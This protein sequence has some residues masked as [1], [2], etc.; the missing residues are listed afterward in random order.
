M[1]SQAGKDEGLFHGLFVGC[2]LSQ[3]KMLQM[4][5]DHE[6]MYLEMILISFSALIAVRVML[7]Q[8]RQRQGH[9]YNRNTLGPSARLSSGCHIPPLWPLWTR[10]VLA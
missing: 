4:H 10:A 6:A 3:E 9:S 8:W 1:F 2:N 5:W 7:M